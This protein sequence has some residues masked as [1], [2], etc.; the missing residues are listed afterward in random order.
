MG[1]TPAGRHLPIV[2]RWNLLERDSAGERR[3]LPRREAVSERERERQGGAL[4]TVVLS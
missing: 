2:N 3:Q 1:L 4:G